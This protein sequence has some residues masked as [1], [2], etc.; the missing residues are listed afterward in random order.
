MF[1][2]CVPS[3]LGPKKQDFWPKINCSQMKLTNFVN[4][5]TDNSSKIGHNFSN[6]L[7]WSKNW[8]YQKIVFTKNV[9]LNKYYSINDL[10][11]SWHRKFTL[12]VRFWHFLTFDDQSVDEFTKY[13]VFI[14]LQLIDGQ[15]SCFLRPTQL[16]K[17]KVNIH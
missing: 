13:S 2:F 16:V 1:T 10:N 17:Q 12:K 7:K 3:W 15:T 8:S 6:K 14:W 11:D 9:L 5:S 4:P